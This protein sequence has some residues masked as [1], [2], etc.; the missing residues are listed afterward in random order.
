[1]VALSVCKLSQRPGLAVGAFVGGKV[2][3]CGILVTDG[4][5]VVGCKVG[6][7]ATDALKCATLSPLVEVQ[8]LMSKYIKQ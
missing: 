1:M 2:S 3:E 7:I 6:S 8:G 4:G 5:A